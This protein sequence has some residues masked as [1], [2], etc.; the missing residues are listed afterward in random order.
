ML[1]RWM[2]SISILALVLLAL[3][4]GRALADLGSDPGSPNVGLRAGTWMPDFAPTN[5]P[6]VRFSQGIDGL[7]TGTA[8]PAD[9][10][11]CGGVQTIFEL[12]EVAGQ[13]GLYA[14]T[15][16]ACEDALQVSQVQV[17][18]QDGASVFSVVGSEDT[19][20]FQG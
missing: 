11:R 9:G 13:P 19:W 18:V 10:Q 17:Q 8:E 14:G 16:V 4:P 2:V 3:G 5:F 1:R 7:W 12:R 6:L 15:Q 20:S